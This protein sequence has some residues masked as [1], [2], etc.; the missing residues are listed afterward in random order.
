MS[1]SFARAEQALLACIQSKITA[2]LVGSPGLGKTAVIRAVAAQL[3]LPC[4][5]LLASNCDAVDIGGLPYIDP[6]T[7]ELRRSLL[8]QIKA[9]VDAP[10]LLFLDEI[11]VV[12]TSVRGP[13][14][15]LLL[16][17]VAGG[18]H[19]H[20]DS[21]VV[22]AANRPEEC[23]G[24]IEMDA[25]SVNRVIRLD[26]FEPTLDELC[27]FYE[28]VGELDTRLH[29]EF[30]D[31]AATLKAEPALLDM[32]P[33]RA[34]IDAGAPFGSPRAWE[35]G[36]RV[37]AQYCETANVGYNVG[38]DEDAVGY[39]LLM[40][41]VGDAKAIAFLAIRKMRKH[42]PTIE[43]I[44]AEPK[45]A[46]IPPDNNKDQ[47]LAAIGLLARVA[48][49]DVWAAWIYTQRLPIE[50]GMACARIL[51]DRQTRYGATHGDSKWLNEGRRIALAVLANGR[52]AM[53]RAG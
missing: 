49:K 41:A 11:S 21:C 25:A 30:V 34:A 31:F 32:K 12:P 1:L 47:Q 8:P 16:E 37:Y 24:G 18:V 4:H 22:A 20:P 28:K 17:H 5:E 52:R 53:P 39:A 3:D 19:L 38:K 45:T 27:A 50:I 10:G 14:M 7:S 26:D 51:M 33:S 46:L 48:E 36:L 43:Q 42:L 13:L 40:G 44:T 6:V 2:L 23:P 35:R 9:C 15:R 29:E